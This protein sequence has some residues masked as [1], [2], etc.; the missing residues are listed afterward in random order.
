MKMFAVVA[1]LVFNTAS[2]FA[3]NDM[4]HMTVAAI[5]WKQLNPAVRARV[6]ALLQKNPNYADWTAGV[7]DPALKDQI[8]FLQAATWADF[9]KR[10]PG[11]INDGDE[12]SGPTASQ[13][14]GYTDKLQHRYFHYID[15]PFSPDG[16]PLEQPKSPNAQT[17]I[18]AFR[19]VL[20][21]P[22]ASD[23]LKSYDLVWLEHLVGDIHQPL[24][25]TSR[26]DKDQPHGDRGG[27]L[28]ATCNTPGCRD[29]LHSFWDGLIGSS[30]DPMAALKA[31]EIIHA[32]DPALARIDDEKAWIQE[33]FEA[34]K[35]SVY[36]DPVGVGAGPFPLNGTYTV[37][38][39]KVAAQRVALAGA[40]LAK[41]INSSFN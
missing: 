31:A 16:T 23:D 25:A 1:L 37:A 7:P 2:V 13:N 28:V 27:N 30:R 39:R 33:S 5:A 19:M 15:L 40:R 3:W 10:A 41:L 17:Q 4:G 20:K 9:I 18:A 29:N 38:A 35:K 21:S 34:A 12:P 6:S 24:H 32:A 8:A 36:A 26:F 14:L 22:T 11:Y